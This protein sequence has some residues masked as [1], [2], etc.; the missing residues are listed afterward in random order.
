LSDK[1]EKGS[2]LDFKKQ[3]KMRHQERRNVHSEGGER[4]REMRKWETP[5]HLNVYKRMPCEAHLTS[6]YLCLGG[7]AVGRGDLRGRTAPVEQA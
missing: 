7:L 1:V 4:E 5:S 3:T 2:D 6:S